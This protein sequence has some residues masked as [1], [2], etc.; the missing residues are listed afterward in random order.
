[1]IVIWTDEAN[2]D[3]LDIYD[4]IAAYDPQAARRFTQ[5]LFDAGDRLDIFPHRG[6]P[7]RGTGMRELFKGSYVIR[8][9]VAPSAVYILSVRHGARPQRP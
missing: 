9:I 5:S 7:V 3:V 4:R 1:L 2:A 8:Y 6:R